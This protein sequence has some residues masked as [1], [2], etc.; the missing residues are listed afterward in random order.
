MGS[1]PPVAPGRVK[2]PEPV[3]G[4]ALAE[5]EEEEELGRAEAVLEGSTP[6]GEASLGEAL[7]EPE[8]AGEPDGERPGLLGDFLPSEPKLWRK[9]RWC[10]TSIILSMVIPLLTVDLFK[11]KVNT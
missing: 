5:D 11:S 10:F 1:A 2:A 4:L 7:W 8:P 9:Q 6:A 3:A